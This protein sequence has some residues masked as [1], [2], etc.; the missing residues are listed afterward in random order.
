[1]NN[2]KKYMKYKQEKSGSQKRGAWSTAC[3]SI[4]RHVKKIFYSPTPLIWTPRD[5]GSVSG[6]PGIRITWYESPKPHWKKNIKRNRVRN[7]RGY[8]MNTYL[9]FY[10]KTFYKPSVFVFSSLH[11]II[12]QSILAKQVIHHFVWHASNV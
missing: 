8:L 2:Y 10:T 11:I 4:C 12:S 7:N 5:T 9:R 1:M 3:W 6:W